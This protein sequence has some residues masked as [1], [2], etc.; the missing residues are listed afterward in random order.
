MEGVLSRI[1]LLLDQ[2][3]YAEAR[4]MLMTQLAEAPGEPT[5]N[6][7]L[8]YCLHCEDRN[9]EAL[10]PAK[11]AVAEA[12]EWPFAFHVL[13]LA[14]KGLEKHKDAHDAIDRAIALDP[15]DATLHA[16]RAALHLE[17]SKWQDAIDAAKV[18][19]RMDPEHSGC[20]NI[21]TAA[22][23]QLGRH[24]EVEELLGEALRL[25]PLDPNALANK[26]WSHLRQGDPSEAMR[27]FKEALRI[28]PGHNGARIG[29]LEALKARNFF[30]R[31]LLAFF[32][33]LGT[34]SPGTQFG[35]LVGLFIA[36]RLIRSIGEKN[37]Q[38]QPFVLPLV[39]AYIAFAYATWVGVYLANCFLLLHPFGRLAMTR[40]EKQ[41]AAL[42]GGVLTAGVV[43]IAGWAYTE[44]LSLQ[45]LG[46]L[47]II[48]TLPLV[49]AQN[50]DSRR[51][52]TIGWSVFGLILG[53]GLIGIYVVPQVYVAAMV[54]FI[55]YVW[56][57]GHYVGRN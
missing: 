2:Q 34:F 6:A 20:L 4:G 13:A 8:S 26:G 24:D 18:G 33:K 25:N 19:L 44:N 30:Y 1:E 23:N 43:A 55:A 21:L 51:A 35:I 7:L 41:N 47:L 31:G 38:L 27:H 9:Q 54:L 17:K 57:I 40:K 49:G 42:L 48:S 32:F 5:L 50:A 12:P 14:Y 28:A 56:F 10:D 3:R 39:I 36:Y 15:H 29:A 45:L 52:K 37:P 53:L 46:I 22:N 16:I 11:R